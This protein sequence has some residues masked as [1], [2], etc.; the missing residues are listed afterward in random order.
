MFALILIF[1]VA[2]LVL[3][4]IDIVAGPTP[5]PPS[6]RFSK[7]IIIVLTLIWLGFV[8]FAPG[9]TAVLFPRPR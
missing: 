7:I 1:A 3:P 9:N 8:L 5:N 4:L 2:F 6:V